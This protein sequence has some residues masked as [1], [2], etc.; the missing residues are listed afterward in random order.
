M[1]CCREKEEIL[2]TPSWLP[3]L[4]HLLFLPVLASSCSSLPALFGSCADSHQLTE[5]EK[6]L[7]FFP[8]VTFPLF[9]WTKLADARAPL[10]SAFWPTETAELEQHT[11]VPLQK[12]DKR[13]GQHAPCFLSFSCLTKVWLLLLL[14]LKDVDRFSPCFRWNPWLHLNLRSSLYQPFQMTALLFEQST[15]SN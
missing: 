10:A 9:W 11:S 12:W 8:R 1:S 6:N 2:Y 15:R 4:L 7:F 5:T 3:V 13:L 14:H